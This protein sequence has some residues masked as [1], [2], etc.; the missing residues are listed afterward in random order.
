MYLK[1]CGR[2][3]NLFV[4]ST[5]P[6]GYHNTLSSMQSFVCTRRVESVL[7]VLELETEIGHNFHFNRFFA[8]FSW[9]AA[10]KISAEQMLPQLQ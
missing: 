3:Q 10:F 6:K 4:I 5:T 9:M 7:I 8:P 1:D 2:E